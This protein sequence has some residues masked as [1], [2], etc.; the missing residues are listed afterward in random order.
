MQK[1]WIRI[2]LWLLSTL[3]GSQS[4]A[5]AQIDVDRVLTIGRNA[6]YFKDY[7]LAI[8]LLNN[9]I[10]TD[11]AR[12]EP[13]YYRAVAKYSLDDYRGS[14]EDAT[15]SITRNPYIYD[16]YYL[17]GIARHS[18]HKDSLA[19]RDY[20]VVLKNNPDH[21]GALHNSAVLYIAQKDTTQARQT[22]DYMKRF[23]PD[24]ATA[25]VIDG[26]LHLQQSDT[27]GAEALFKK[28][29]DLAPGLTGAY[30]A[31][32]EIMYDKADYPAAESYLNNALEHNP[33]EA[34]LYINRALMRYKQ[35]NFRG[36]MN[37]Y[38]TAV[39]MEPN[40]TLARYNRGL[41][42]T[43]VGELNGALE[44][45]NVVV[46]NDPSNYFATFNRA[47][48]SNQVGNPKLA[49]SDLDKIIQR[50]PTFVPAYTERSNAYTLIG[51]EGA[52]RKDLYHASKLIYDS[53]TADKARKKQDAQQ[54]ATTDTIA[55]NEVRDDRDE[56]IRKFKLLVINSRE[57][58]YNQLY[59]EEGENIR[60]RIQDRE[61]AVDL[62]PMFQLSYY[63]KTDSQLRIASGKNYTTALRLNEQDG[64]QISVIYDL[65][66]LSEPQLREHLSPSGTPFSQAMDYLTIKD[67]DSVV[68][69]LT[70]AITEQP[71][72]PALYFQ[73][74]TSRILAFRATHRDTEPDLLLRKA[75]SEA[76]I[77]DFQKVLELVP[78]YAPA[79]YNLGCIYYTIGQYHQAREYFEHAI[80]ADHEMGVAYF[81]LGL[82]L[83][84]LGEKEKADSYMSKA[85]TLGIYDAYSIIRRMQ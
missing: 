31:M 61:T 9:A 36:A 52:A 66:Q 41:L 65:P 30:L 44:D 81:N 3:V 64:R 8:Q 38:S 63:T 42:R 78:N 10:R 14:E 57:K 39:Q 20:Q 56:N 18:L 45:F 27:I 54:E 11:S 34:N 5:L 21:K 50:Y 69:A 72:M 12:A 23:F 58:A 76:A 22:L 71:T 33:G 4:I 2:I 62:R 55:T 29:I 60:G 77:S 70:Q 68:Q 79:L 75:V 82:T 46:R 85:G 28:A 40:N 32:A 43:Q 84:A 13:Y 49:L 19:L 51:Q 35:N 47:I 7:V 80:K 24:Y 67:H 1:R 59:S 16:A 15:H 53:R 6:I 74:G 73:R 83:Y 48:L 17:R 37:D 26:G 25:Y